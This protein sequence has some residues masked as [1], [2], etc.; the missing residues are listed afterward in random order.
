M[1]KFVLAG[2]GDDHR[3][4]VLH[5]IPIR[6]EDRSVNLVEGLSLSDPLPAPPASSTAEFLDLAEYGMRCPDGTAFWALFTQAP[7]EEF[8]MHY[9][10]TIDF[11]LIVSGSTTL[12]LEDGEV[13]LGSGDCVLI[14]GVPHAWRAGPDG[15]QLSS[16]LVGR[17]LNQQPQA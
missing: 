12:T 3:S 13:D 4:T 6:D 9:T 1:R 2:W 16:M 15:C 5:T 14:N 11:D 10:E 17:A 7:G 8:G